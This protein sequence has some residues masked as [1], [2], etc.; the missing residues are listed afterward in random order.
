[1][2]GKIT[3]LDDPN[4]PYGG[5]KVTAEE[6]LKRQQQQER[7]AVASTPVPPPER[8]P[9]FR[10]NL[11]NARVVAEG[12]WNDATSFVKSIVP[13]AQAEA[14]ENRNRR[15]NRAVDEAENGAKRK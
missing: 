10:D 2:S 12:L 3:R 9:G 7:R 13:R 5:R 14:Q 4:N 1:M 6:L 11:N 8:K 15:I